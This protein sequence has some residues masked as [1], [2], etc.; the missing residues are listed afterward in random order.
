VTTCQ[1]ATKMVNADGTSGTFDTGAR[2]IMM[3]QLGCCS[4]D[5]HLGLLNQLFARCRLSTKWEVVQ[6]YSGTRWPW[7]RVRLVS[8]GWLFAAESVNNLN[9]RHIKLLSSPKAPSAGTDFLATEPYL[10][11]SFSV[12]FRMSITL[13]TITTSRQSHG[14]FA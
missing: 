11:V 14:I 13:I 10:I 9:A 1:L 4:F 2:G 8:R 7:F 12:A 6:G 3:P 5:S